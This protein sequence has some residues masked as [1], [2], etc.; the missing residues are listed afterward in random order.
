[1]TEN[2]KLEFRKSQ[3]ARFHLPRRAGKVGCGVVLGAY[4]GAG[5]Y[6]ALETQ[7]QVQPLQEELNTRLFGQLCWNSLPSAQL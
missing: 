6:R 3:E 1:M 4:P 2:R 7:L 5:V